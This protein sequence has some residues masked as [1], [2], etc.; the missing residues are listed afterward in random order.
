MLCS[1]LTGSDGPE[2]VQN[3]S[4]GS[5]CML[6]HTPAWPRV[7]KALLPFNGAILKIAAIPFIYRRCLTFLRRNWKPGCSRSSRSMGV[8]RYAYLPTPPPPPPPPDNPRP[9]LPLSTV[10]R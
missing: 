2:T 4:A 3:A 7:S 6:H 9:L 1:R 5:C 10:V 8:Y